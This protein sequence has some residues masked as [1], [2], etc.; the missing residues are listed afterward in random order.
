MYFFCDIK[1]RFI[2]QTCLLQLTMPEKSIRPIGLPSRQVPLGAK[3]QMIGW[4]TNKKEVNSNLS[5]VTLKTI[6][7]QKCQKMHDKK[8]TYYEFCTLP[9]L[10]DDSPKVSYTRLKDLIKKKSV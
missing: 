3:L 1:K 2:V 6:D 10:S 5:E 9:E 7:R 4:M 8:L